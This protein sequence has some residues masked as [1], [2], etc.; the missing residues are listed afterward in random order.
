MNRTRVM[1]ILP[2]FGPGGAERMSVHLMNALNREDF[3]VA[4]ISLYDRVG[5]DLEE[6]LA[7]SKIPT[8]Y[9]GKRPGPDP[10]MVSRITRAIKAFH[11]QVVHTHRYVLRYS[12]LPAL[13]CRVPAM[14][15]TVHNT[16]ENEVDKAGRLVHRLAFKHGVTPVAIAHEVARSLTNVYGVH[17]FPL[18][19]NGIPVEPFSKP[20]VSRDAWR[21]RE[22]FEQEDVLFVCVA[23]LSPQKT[24][25]LLL[26]AFRRGPGLSDSRARLLLVGVGE[27]HDKLQAEARHLGL[28]DRVSFMGIR[29]DIPEV[30]NAAD[31][32]V[33]SSNWE[34]NP[35]S[36]MEAMA[37]GKPVISTAVGGVPELVEEGKSGFL[38][39][40]GNATALAQA[41]NLLLK[42]RKLRQ[43]MGKAA[44]KRAIEHFDLRAMTEAY[45]SLYETMLS[46]KS[47][48]A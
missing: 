44:S 48:H 3:E 23:R 9:L 28:G 16:A 47:P 40:R 24:H 37:A 33:L 41:M 29:T 36:V 6:M 39:K 19:T 8:W 45:V 32:F 20:K 34:G 1:H 15:H 31:V 22:G 42:D 25:S 5:T 14:L 21:G 13:Y 12:L 4:A 27:L 11:P 30:L 43:T 38:V 46:K 26:E 10:R 7:E 35:L 18:I 17:E 2:N